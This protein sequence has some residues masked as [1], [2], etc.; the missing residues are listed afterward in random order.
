ML[1][2]RRWMIGTTIALGTAVLLYFLPL[3]H[4]VPLSAKNATSSGGASALGTSATGQSPQSIFEPTAFVNEFWRQ[5]LLPGS[6][7]A[8]DASNLIDAIAR[9][10]RDA[11]K[12]YGRRVSV[13]SVYYYF[14]KGTGRVVSVEK[15]SIGLAVHDGQSRIQVSLEIGPIFGNAVRD[16]TGLLDLNNFANSQDFNAVSSEINR[17]IESDVQP[18]LRNLATIDAEILFVG[19]VE[20]TDEAIDLQPLRVVPFIAESL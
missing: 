3:F 19:C 2:G 9:D 20:V 1:I 15:N 8:V 17:R 11:K 4:V 12:T 14:I 7:D 18:M 10:P 6:S 16:G 5:R 13:G